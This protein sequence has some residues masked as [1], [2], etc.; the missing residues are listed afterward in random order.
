MNVVV[1][2]KSILTH[3]N[4]SKKLDDDDNDDLKTNFFLFVYE[5]KLIKQKRL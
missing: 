4:P 1:P 3:I 2:S 5:K